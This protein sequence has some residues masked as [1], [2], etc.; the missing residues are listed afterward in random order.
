MGLLCLLTLLNVINF[1]DRQLLASFANF[2]V[3][4]LQLTNAQFGLLTGLL[5]VASYSV[6]GI[7]MGAL[8]DTVHRPR[9]VASGVT[10]WSALTA[11][12]G[13]A[14]GFLSLAIPRMFI[15]VGE[16]VLTPAA[17]S[18]LSDRFPRKKLGFASG[19]YYMGVPI[20]FGA[21]LLIAG[22]LGPKIGWRIC[23]FSLGALGIVL[24]GTIL[25]IPETR[26]NAMT[27]LQGRASKL[28]LGK[29]IAEIW[30]LL[31]RSHALRWTI[32]GGVIVHFIV[33]ASTFEQLWFVQERGFERAYIA[34]VTGWIAVVGGVLGNLFGGIGS[35]WWQQNRSG[36]RAAFYSWTL[37][38]LV[39]VNILYRLVDPAELFFW[40]GVFCNYF[41]LGAFYGPAFSTVQDLVPAANRGTIVAFYLLMNSLVGVGLGTTLSGYLIDY[42]ILI[43]VNEPYS[44]VIL[45]L[46]VL[47]AGAIIA[48]RMAGQWFTRDCQQV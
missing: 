22:Y 9:L 35:D 8:A 12:S 32:I 21:S 27:L 4:E 1:V 15:A 29:K 40:F 13:A 7:F 6:I 17:M 28:G 34:Q 10:L 11:A 20:G 33:A 2:I 30:E 31:K 26:K 46:M 45:I 23:F 3:P 38:A 14:V 41:L 47:S 16:S 19:F 43:G 25:F 18:M 36:G 37:L 24:A 44:K 48:F 5:F 42:F 39:P